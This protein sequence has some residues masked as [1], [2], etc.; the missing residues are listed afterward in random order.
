MTFRTN[1][2]RTGEIKVSR[3]PT[4]PYGWDNE[5]CKSKYENSQFNVGWFKHTVM[6]T[7]NWSVTL[8]QTKMSDNIHLVL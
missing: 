4:A 1:G 3:L 8:I 6:N 5:Y 7:I 2:F